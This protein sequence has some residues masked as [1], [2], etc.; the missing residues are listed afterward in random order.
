MSVEA[1]FRALSPTDGHS[2]FLFPHPQAASSFQNY[3]P[4]PL[5]L[6][7]AI[8]LT[9]IQEEIPFWTPWGA[10]VEGRKTMNTDVGTVG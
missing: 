1:S 8:G 6:P 5:P 3:T 2:Y 10:D 4:I 9:L 7:K